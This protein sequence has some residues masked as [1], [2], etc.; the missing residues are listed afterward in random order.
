MPPKPTE[1]FLQSQADAGITDLSYSIGLQVR[2]N[3][4]VRA[5]AWGGPGYR[6]GLRPGDKILSVNSEPFT[7]LMLLAAVSSSATS[8]VRISVQANG[9]IREFILPY[10]GPLRYPILERISG[11]P[12]WLTPLLSPR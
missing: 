10:A 8:P 11:A 6:A 7:S 1:T 5:V 9:V 2:E 4:A 3:G 12:D